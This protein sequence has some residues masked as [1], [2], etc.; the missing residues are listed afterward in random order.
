MNHTSPFGPMTG[1]MPE[2]K[3]P[4]IRENVGHVEEGQIRVGGVGLRSVVRIGGQY[5]TKSGRIKFIVHH[6]GRSARGDLG[7]WETMYVT[8]IITRWPDVEDP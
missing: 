4:R 3:A 6:Y 5:L 7:V 1:P 8:T 2:T